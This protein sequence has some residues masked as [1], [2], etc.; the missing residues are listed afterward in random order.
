MADQRPSLG[1]ALIALGTG[2]LKAVQYANVNGK[3]MFEGDIVLGPVD[4]VERTT[5]A[6]RA[7]GG[8]AARAAAMMP[9]RRAELPSLTMA[10]GF[11]VTIESHRWPDG[12]VPVE[13]DPN[14][15]AKHRV[16]QAI[17]HWVEKTSFTFPTHTTQDSWVFFTD[18]DGKCN[19]QVG[20]VGGRQ[21]INLGPDC[22]RGEAIHEIGHAIGL[23]HEQ[24]RRDRDLFV[25]IIWENIDPEAR[26]NFEQQISDADSIGPYDYDSI[27]HYGRKF[28]SINGGDTIVPTLNPNARIGQTDGLSQGDVSA[29]NAMFRPMGH[30]NVQDMF[31]KQEKDAV[32]DHKGKDVKDSEEKKKEG[33][34]DF[35]KKTETHE[36]GKERQGKELETSPR[37]VGLGGDKQIGDR[38][39]GLERAIGDLVHFIP[40]HL[41]PDLTASAL[42]N[43]PS[44]DAVELQRLSAELL[45]RAGDAKDAKDA[46]DVKDQEKAAEF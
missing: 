9:G 24:S 41:R 34:K 45:R 17:D 5:E 28:F 29:A 39:A 12:V 6:L 19:S 42:V 25:R 23:W 37:T 40:P 13:I 26:H 11:G 20:M 30:K 18:T 43:E 32:G 46:K 3:A 27:M 36:K 44:A 8:P 35:E 31:A 22:Q 10:P 21:L 2:E 4:E 15:P 7:A 1:T 33:S 38:L 16:T 14:L